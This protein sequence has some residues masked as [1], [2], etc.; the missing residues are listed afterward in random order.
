MQDFRSPEELV[1]IGDSRDMN[2]IRDNSVKVCVTSP[3]YFRNKTYETQYSTYEEYRSYLK[4]VWLQVFQKLST[5][6]LL[7][8]NIGNSFDNQFK[9]HD[10]ARDIEK[11]GFHLV[12]SVIWVKGHHSPVQGT[13]RLLRLC[14][15]IW[16]F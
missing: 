1:V 9:S 14:V 8:V 4:Q 11:C 10:I 5:K 2:F 16:I 13:I 7:F 3:P 6:G 15:F 12:Q